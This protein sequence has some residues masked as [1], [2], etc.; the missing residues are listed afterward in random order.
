ME[1]KQKANTIIEKIQQGQH[2]L[3]QREVVEIEQQLKKI[4]E[5]SNAELLFLHHTAALFY[6]AEKNYS[7]ASHHFQQAM[8]HR[9]RDKEAEE[10]WLQAHLA[11]AKLDEQF[12]QFSQARMTLAKVLQYLEKKQADNTEIAR[13]YQRIGWLFY[14]EEELHQAH[15]QMEQAR[16]LLLEELEPVDPMVMKVTDQLADI[17]V[18]LEQPA[19]A[20]QL[21]DN[22][23]AR[24]DTLLSDEG[25]ATLLMKTGELHFHIDLK[26]ARRI[27]DQ[28]VK[29]VN[30]EHPLS[31]RGFMLLAEIEENLTAFPRAVKYYERA[32]EIINQKYEKDHFLVVFLYSKLGTIALKMGEDQK[33]KRFLEAGLPL[34]D[35][36]PKIRMQFLYAL[37]KIYSK[38]EIYE[39]AM[40]MYTDFLQ[41]LEAQ[42]KMR[43]LAYANTL[44]AIAYNFLMQ[45][46]V[47]NAIV[48]YH[49]A[50]SIYEKLGSNCRNEKG[51]TAIRLGYSYYQAGEIKQA[52]KY[53]E[54]GAET[55]EKVNDQAI[56]QEAYL[57]LIEFYKETNQPKKQYQYEHKL[58]QFNK[59]SI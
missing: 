6:Q 41:G 36:Y 57:A 53:Y 23:I 12:K 21:F 25:K 5:L 33:A 52:E 58:I 31:V 55:I 49:E 48:R 26:K 10:I 14:Q 50:L 22:I 28:A 38:Q 35:K 16:K 30:T 42:D 37:G 40:D 51:L 8:K 4:E 2:H 54:L 47:D 24:E 17:Y 3:V 59:K 7:L 32:L 56:K 27:I 18:A 13:V 15:T 20:I 34:S 44:Q 46:D 39:Q 43:T 1:W 29:L 45:A 9:Y 11:F 19:L